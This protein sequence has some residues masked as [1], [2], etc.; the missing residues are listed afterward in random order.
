MPGPLPT[1]DEFFPLHLGDPVP[2]AYFDATQ[3]VLGSLGR[4]DL[5]LANTT[6]IKANAGTGPD[7][8]GMGIGGALRFN[9]A[10][11]EQSMPGGSGSGRYS[12]FVT[13]GVTALSGTEEDATDY[14]W[15]LAIIK[16]GGGNP[17]TAHFKL[18]GYLDFDG[19]KIT[20]V[21]QMFGRRDDAPKAAVSPSVNVPGVE[22][23][24]PAA[25][26]ANAFQASVGGSQVFAVGPSGAITI[27]AGLNATTAALS[28]NDRSALTLTG[29]A[30]GITFGGDTQ[31]YRSAT[32]LLASPGSL[33][34]GGFF[35]ANQ[36][37]FLGGKVWFGPSGG[38]TFDTTI[39]RISAAVLKTQGTWQVGGNLALTSNGGALLFGASGDTNLYRAGV[40]V[41]KTDGELVVGGG[42]KV[43]G[44]TSYVGGT[45]GFFGA[46][47]V[48]QRVG[49][50]SPSPPGGAFRTPLTYGSTMKQVIDYLSTLASDLRAY[51]LLGA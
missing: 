47:P 26:V 29:S 37:A 41:L 46:S 28:K 12:I 13:T 49:W 2:V 6:T 39:E 50:G 23:I 45:L 4:L 20:R 19:S 36:E 43:T 24:M 44:E 10:A 1:T 32:N 9:T 51:G 21:V 17:G 27:T 11:V 31:F 38:A 16:E 40:G 48:S 42:V 5:T 35:Q 18:V 14:S 30:A 25:A 8:A 33:A 22:S 3:E 15:Q 7:K 34:L